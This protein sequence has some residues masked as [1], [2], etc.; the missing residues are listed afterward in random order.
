[1]GQVV[2]ANHLFKVAKGDKKVEEATSD[3]VQTYLDSRGLIM[4]IIKAVRV[5]KMMKILLL[6]RGH[7]MNSCK[8][9]KLVL[10]TCRESSMKALVLVNRREVAIDVHSV[11]Y[12]CK[13]KG[14]HGPGGV[15]CPPSDK[16]SKLYACML[17][18]QTGG[19]VLFRRGKDAEPVSDPES[20]LG[21]AVSTDT[22][23]VDCS[24]SGLVG[25]RGV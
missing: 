7:P 18:H 14:S 25:L 5:G 17:S 20:G 22:F 12:L 9:C 19:P 10:G 23:V 21:C 6:Q 16:H 8:T 24:A 11:L 3:P 1:V 4:V 13:T 15:F 2:D